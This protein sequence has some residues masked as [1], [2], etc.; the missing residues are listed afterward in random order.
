MQPYSQQWDTD[1]FF[2]IRISDQQTTRI[3]P[4][5]GVLAYDAKNT[6]P[7][8]LTI[9]NQGTSPIITINPNANS[10]AAPVADP[11]STLKFCRQYNASDKKLSFTYAIKNNAQ[12]SILTELATSLFVE[13]FKTTVPVRYT[14]CTSD[15]S[16]CTSRI[17]DGNFRL[18]AG[19]TAE[20][21]G[22]AILPSKPPKNDF[23]IRTSLRYDYN[24]EKLVPY[25]V[26]TATGTCS[27]KPT[28]V[29]S[30]EVP[31]AT[32]SAP[33][34]VTPEPGDEAGLVNINFCRSYDAASRKVS[35]SY[36][37]R[38]SSS[39]E[40]PLELATSLAVEGQKDVAMV[41]YTGCESGGSSCISRISSGIFKLK[42]GETAKFS[43]EAT[44]S[45]KPAKANF[46]IRTSLRYD[47]K[48]RT[49]IPFLIGYASDSCSANPSG[50]APSIITVTPEPGNEAGLVNVS[51]CRSYDAGSRKVSFA[52][53]LRNRSSVTIPV[54]L[55]TSLA[56]EGL[57]YTVPVR[58]TGCVSG[59]SSCASRISSGIF[60]LNAGE[61]AEFRGEA[62]LPSKPANPNFFIKTSL[63]YDYKGRTL[64]PFLVGYTVN[65]CS[66]PHAVSAD[67]ILPK[68][69]DASVLAV[70]IIN[71][72]DTEMTILPGTVVRGDQVIGNYEG[73]AAI[74]A[75]DV[76][77]TGHSDFA[78]TK[79]EE[80]ILPPYSI[81][82]TT[83]TL[84]AGM[85]VDDGTVWN[86]SINGTASGITPEKS[87]PK[88]LA[89]P[90]SGTTGDND[91]RQLFRIGDQRIPD[92]LP[93]TGFST[94]RVTKLS[95]QPESLAYRSL[96]GLHL[97]IPAILTSADIVGIP[98]TGNGEWA[99][100]WLKDR[101]GVLEN[102]PLPGSGIS[103]I[104]AHN[105][106]NDTQNGPFIGLSILQDNDRIFVGDDSGGLQTFSVYANLLLSPDD[107]NRIYQTAY[108][109][110]L[111]LLPCEAETAEGGYAF[112]RAVFAEP[113]NRD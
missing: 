3:L 105:H 45:A 48:G 113:V 112:R 4:I 82:D 38:N 47:Y 78:F 33:I 85:A 24:G 70:R 111:V 102:T 20:F 88:A 26:G 67:E 86:Y 17:T 8:K 10:G 109:G 16:S 2:S 76:E 23:L 110:S 91:D 53:A 99:V 56:V 46:Y 22:E 89:A 73:I 5:A 101:A 108:P 54:E 42:A 97:E 35:F 52:Y 71:D 104:A 11:L 77:I 81:A 100:E 21:S 32:A 15:G 94:R 51:F 43:G 64:I 65:A 1:V 107:G 69:S 39:A 59:G 90:E 13:G 18:R 40:I 9:V 103:V 72:K 29:P 62:S 83:L 49:L 30:A 79:G 93:A 31:S 27:E 92:R 28:A 95:V 7:E 84:P 106:L 12:D 6:T 14:G 96:N 25:L 57:R 37:L 34:T 63:R 74:S 50:T 36:T 75:V 60:R 98:L 58:Y 19:E 41:R 87:Q 44:L 61:T 66:A 80:F 55:A 68:S